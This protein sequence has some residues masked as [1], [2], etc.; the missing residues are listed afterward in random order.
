MTNHSSNSLRRKSVA[1]AAFVF[2]AALAG[3]A[4][5]EKSCGTQ[6]KID[7]PDSEVEFSKK[8]GEALF[9]HFVVPPEKWKTSFG[10]RQLGGYVANDRIG[11]KSLCKRDINN[12]RS[13]GTGEVTYITQPTADAL[14]GKSTL[15]Q[16]CREKVRSIEKLPPEKVAEQDELRQ[17][18]RAIAGNRGGL[19]FTAEE[20]RQ[21]SE[22]DGKIR[23]IQSQH[24]ESVRPQTSALRK[25]CDVK[26]DA[27]FKEQRFDLRLVVNSPSKISLF[28]GDHV[29]DDFGDRNLRTG[30]SD[31]LRRISVLLK[32]QNNTAPNAQDIALAKSMLDIQGLKALIDKGGNLP[33]DA[34]IQSLKDIQNAAIKVQ[35]DWIKQQERQLA[36]TERDARQQRQ[37][38]E[39]AAR[40]AAPAPSRAPAPAP[41]QTANS[42]APAPA[43]STA[44]SPAPVPAPAVP[45]VPQLP[46]NVGNVLRGVFGR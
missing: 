38:D 10:Y 22:I 35:D 27:I 36:Q 45:N 13:S 44:Q 19:A 32:M 11:S 16:E 43:P 29:I 40:R 25:E 39:A 21:M 8:L 9:V 30:P 3:Q 41:A 14:I 23:A 37:N 34:E 42:P 17:Q 24:E 5:A 12:I 33:S 20:R 28:Q 4:F 7:A 46:S 26:N 18:R 6:G 1:T 15:G 2:C 31:K